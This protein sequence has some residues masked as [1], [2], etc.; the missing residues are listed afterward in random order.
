MNHS[1]CSWVSS[2]PLYINYHDTEWWNSNHLGDDRYL[3]EMLSLE[4]AQAGLSW[5]T[6][7]KRRENYK[8]I[9]EDFDVQKISEYSDAKLQEILKNEGII[10]NRLKVFSVR[11]NAQAFLSIQKEFWSFKNYLESFTKWMR[12]V[13]R[14]ENLKDYPTKN[15]ISDG[16]SRNL[17]KRGMSFVGSTIIYAY[18][19][20]IGLVDDHQPQCFCCKI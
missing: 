16:I 1:R 5:I 20:A 4:W 19:Q 14:F 3:F 15:E 2:A 10:R 9:F 8:Q 17:K 6:V 11:K 13:H 12:E 18:M 7:L